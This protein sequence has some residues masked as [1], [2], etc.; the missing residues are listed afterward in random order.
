MA[1]FYRRACAFLS[2][3][4]GLSPVGFVAGDA[5]RAALRVASLCLYTLLPSSASHA[6]EFVRLDYNLTL[7]ARSQNTVFLELFSDRPLTT[8]NFLNYVNNPIANGSYNGTVM[9]R[10]SRNFVIQGGGY[11][12]V[13]IN[14]P[15]LNDKSLDPTQVV[16]LDGNSGTANP[17]VNNEYANPP[18]R[19]NSRG[20][21]SMARIGGQPNSATNQWFIN[22]ANN[23]NL[24]TVDGGFTAFGHVVGNGMTL[25]DAFNTLA[26]KNLN[27]DTNDDGVRES[28]PF[29][30]PFGGTDQN[31]QPL[32]GVPYLAAGGNNILVVLDKATQIDYL[33]LGLTTD[34]PAGGISFNARDAYI[35]TGTVF[36]GTGGLTI[37]NGRTLGIREGYALNRPL[38]NHGTLAPGL[39][40]GKITVDST[41][42]QYSD[43][44]LA[45]QLR[46]TTADTLYDQLDVNGIAFLTGKLSVSLL[47]SF[48][49]AKNNTFTLLTADSIIGTFGAYDLPQ[50]SAGL[51]W[52]INQTVTAITLTVAQADF[53]R[54]G[55]VDSG[56][57]IVW[58]KTRNLT[59]TANSGADGDGNGI[60]NDLDLAIWRN[61]LGNRAGGT[62]GAG[63]DGGG[64]LGTIVPEP[65]SSMLAAAAVFIFS[66]ATRRRRR[67]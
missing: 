56:D 21:I 8:A 62:F 18:V 9:H 42:S 37:G 26:I 5:F 40:L 27:P 46:G 59:V 67:M 2:I 23:P 29:F 7:D 34:V 10:L 13:L 14:E 35:D 1:V 45:L 47:N 36:T 32:D 31:G 16:D 48:V 49:P 58:R 17:T 43:G 41:Y 61:N 3:L 19:S 11:R 6:N 33:G 15:A 38:S 65:A 51:V 63:M 57:Y 54:N 52:D 50:L 55:V 22:L 39:Q 20:T 30:N 60:V 53:N 12:P 24:D 4:R 28:G 66:A 25:F 44:T 64:L